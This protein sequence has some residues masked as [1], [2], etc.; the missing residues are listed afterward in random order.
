MEVLFTVALFIPLILLLWLA[1]VA[2][3]RRQQVPPRQDV[4]MLVYGLLAA[5]WL[6]W[7]MA[8]VFFMLLGIAYQ[9]YADVDAMASVY[10]AQGVDPQVMIHIMLALPRLGGGLAVLSGL[11]LLTL[12]RPAR[13]W[14]AHFIPIDAENVVHMVALSYSGLIFVNLWLVMGIGMEQMVGMMEQT[15]DMGT[16]QMMSLLWVQDLALA[17]MALVG[18]GWPSRRD[19]RS[20]MARLGLVWPTRR[21]VMLGLGLGLGMVAVLFPGLYVLEKMGLG[22]NPDIERLT[23]EMLGPLLTSL[24]GV[25]TL[26]LA[27]ALGEELVY[28]GALQPRF[29]LVVTAALFALTHNQYGLS[30]ATLVVFVLGLVLGWTRQRAN[31]TTAMILHATYNIAIGLAGMFWQ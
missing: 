2:E 23:E 12:V 11:G 8:G 27:A 10:E 13:R 1:H 20:A 16:S 18:V 19:W 4:A 5:F 9:R 28:R 25:L 7:L 29:G 26:G 6:G 14:L 30:V 21:Q 17:V 31:T 24:P 22:M 3:K 15:G